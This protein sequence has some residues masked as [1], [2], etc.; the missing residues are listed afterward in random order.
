MK[1]KNQNNVIVVIK[2]QQ[3]NVKIV[4]WYIVNN[5]KN[6]YIMQLVMLNILDSLII[7][8]INH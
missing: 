7:N 8:K 6:N 3:Y 4:I 2:Q 1:T 5:V